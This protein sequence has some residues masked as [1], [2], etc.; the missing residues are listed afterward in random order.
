MSSAH[1]DLNANAAYIRR[2][3]IGHLLSLGTIRLIRR[4]WAQCRSS[5]KS[6]QTLLEY[7]ATAQGLRI[8]S[9]SGSHAGGMQRPERS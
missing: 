5:V 7:F 9:R 8:L 3:S 6:R 2:T 4:R 1:H